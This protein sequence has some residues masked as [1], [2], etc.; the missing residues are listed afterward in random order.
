[1]QKIIFG[2]TLV[3]LLSAG[4]EIS[5]QKITKKIKET[6]KQTTEQKAEQKTAEGVSQGIDKGILGAK[7]IFKKKDKKDEK[8]DS[9]SKSI[10]DTETVISDGAETDNPDTTRSFG[11]YTNFTFEPG[12]K[13]LFFDDFSKDKLGDFP[14]NWETSGSGEVVK[15]SSYDG[16]WFSFTGR[17]G[18]VPLSGEL[19]EN[20]TVE[21]D[22]ATNGFSENNSATTLTLAFLNKKSYN[23]GSAGGHGHIQISL[24]RSA[25][26]SAGNTG[27]EKTPR[28]NSKLNRNFKLDTLIH[29]S[30]AVNKNRL[31]IWM[32]EEKI[33]DIPS[34][35]VGNM[36]RYLLFE[37]SGIN[38]EKGHVV[39]ISNFKV[40]EAKEDL[41]SRLLES[42][43]F[44]TT[45]IYFNTDKADIKPESFAIIKSVA[46]YLKENPD[47][48][49]QIIGHTDAQGE[50]QYNQ[51]LSEKRASA[52]LRSL[53]D[54]FGIEEGRM[55]AA[56]KGEAEPVDDNA[57]EKGRANNRRVEFV[58][59]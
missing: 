5:A 30:V 27:A 18:Y 1:M 55:T 51:Q 6:A 36:G 40:A 32:Q 58:K 33:V 9:A 12:N 22:L 47:T 44:S 4:K 48:K 45:G 59:M 20:Y 50:E 53:V 11:I 15:N 28:I 37:S 2:S 52:V 16:N 43:R 34:L 35:L 42:G 54:H 31:R 23:M 46:D 13:I 29:F 26:M 21:F 8:S 38:P 14:V 41:R 3:F 17:N 24:H 25:T 56:G 39:L 57:S 7:N 49:I 19:P 10:N